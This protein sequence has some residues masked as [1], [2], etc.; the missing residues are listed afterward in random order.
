MDFFIFIQSKMEIS[1]FLTKG[2]IR[3]A[4]PR[5]IYCCPSKITLSVH[6][7]KKN[8]LELYRTEIGYEQ[9]HIYLTYINTKYNL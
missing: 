8:S 3:Q 1:K 6:K 5:N 4:N 9:D 7:E 2:G